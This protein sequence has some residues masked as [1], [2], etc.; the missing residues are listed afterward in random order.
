LGGEI[1]LKIE[2]LYFE[3]CPS[4]E[5]TLSLLER[6]LEEEGI[7]PKVQTIQVELEES[8]KKRKFLGS[9]SIRVDRLDIE[10]AART[11]THFGKQCRVYDDNGVSRGVPPERLIRQ[12]IREAGE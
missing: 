4:Y 1:R 3:G 6:I 8:A 10:V 5:P 12:A 11:A 2:L 7:S 9:P